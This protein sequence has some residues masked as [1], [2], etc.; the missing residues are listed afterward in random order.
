MDCLN[1]RVKA[2]RWKHGGK[3]SQFAN[4]ILDVT[5]K[6]CATKGKIDKLYFIKI[7][8]FFASSDTIES[9]KATHRVEGVF[10]NHRS[11]KD[12]ISEYVGKS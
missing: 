7:K 11:D 9:E 4:G 10:V 6:A 3:S 8:N 1:M 12:L 5:L 2:H